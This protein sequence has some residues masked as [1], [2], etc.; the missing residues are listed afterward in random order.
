VTSEPR[1]NRSTSHNAFG[2]AIDAVD[3]INCSGLASGHGVGRRPPTVIELAAPGQLE[4]VWPSERAQTTR[5]L[6]AGGALIFSVAHVAGLG[7][8]LTMPAYGRF[9]VGEDGG[10]IRCD[11]AAVGSWTTGLLVQ[12]LPLACT[13]RGFEPFHASG[14]VLERGAL[15]ISGPVTAGKSTLA[16]AL[17]QSGA[18]LLSDDVVALEV[19][20]ETIVAH[21]GGRWLHLRGS[22]HEHAVAPRGGGLQ[23]AGWEDGRRRYLAPL[24][25]GPEPLRAVY[26][27]ERGDAGDKASVRPAGGSGLA[28]LAATYNLSVREP[29]R[30]RRQLELAHRLASTVP[31]FSLAEAHGE[32]AGRL[33][34]LVRRHFESQA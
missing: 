15:M 25:A 34:A 23:P 19:C 13:L 16:A 20:D 26:L 33:V 8:L 14:V 22:R 12:A 6:R 21:P 7:Y 5:E 3:G 18:T 29:R 9:L 30:L 32:D 1:P 17:V 24:A 11:P 4:R 28:L 2:L 31:V 10:R 27:L